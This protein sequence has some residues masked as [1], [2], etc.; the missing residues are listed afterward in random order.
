MPVTVRI[1]T[2]LRSLTNCTAEVQAKGDTVDDLVLAW[3]GRARDRR[4]KDAR[5]SSSFSSALISRT[6]GS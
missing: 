3:R 6:R 1:P 4:A 2:P 5:C